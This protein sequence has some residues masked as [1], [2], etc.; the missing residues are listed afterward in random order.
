MA[1]AT[2]RLFKVNPSTN[3]YDSVDGGNQLGCVIMGTGTTFQIL[4]YNGQVRAFDDLDFP[5]RFLCNHRKLLRR[6][7]C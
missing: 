5:L 7:L 4:I 1:S 6:L 2:V 3:A